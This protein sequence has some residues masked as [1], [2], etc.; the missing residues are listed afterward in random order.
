MLQI[1]HITYMR[2]CLNLPPGRRG[3]ILTALPMH[4]SSPGG[5]VRFFQT[6]YFRSAGYL[7]SAV[8]L[9]CSAA[10]AEQ[11]VC[12]TTYGGETKMLVAQPVTSPY[13]VSS[14]QVGSYFRFRVV[15]QNTPAD[16]ASIKVYTYADHDDGA[17]LIHQATYPYPPPKHRNGRNAPYGFS[18]LQFVYETLRDG[19]LQYWCE[20]KPTTK[21]RAR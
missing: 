8:L 19:E 9:A 14:I 5:V 21:G 7:L 10:H 13:A 18:G 3:D 16:L 12:H 15:F 6:S 11:A 17:V 4:A 1:L 2:F 20:M